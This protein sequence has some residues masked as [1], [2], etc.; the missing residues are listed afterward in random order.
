MINGIIGK[1]IGMTQHFGDDG[2]LEAVTAI[3]AGPC[4]VTQVKTATQDGYQAVQ[5]GFG[6][7]KRLNQPEQ[8]HLKGLGLFRHLREFRVVDTSGLE[9]GQRVTADL[10]KEGELVN[11][12]GTSKGKGF[13]GVVK[14]HGFAGGPK[15]HGQSD[16]HRARGSVG[17]TTPGRVLKGTKM[18]GHMGN[19]RVTVRNLKVLKA[20][21][22]RG[23]LLLRG[24]VPGSRNSLVLIRKVKEGGD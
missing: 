16:R 15:T 7:A 2:T 23:L 18:A 24:A 19:H 9:L 20:D 8:G 3:E 11:V 12:T 13:A 10:F 4:T 6:L 21:A 22:E 1:K 14:R 5:L 17:A